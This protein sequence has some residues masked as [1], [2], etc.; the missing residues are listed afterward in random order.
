MNNNGTLISLNSISKYYN[1]GKVKVKALENI[2][3]EIKRGE[4]VA[5]IGPSGSGKS[6]LMNIMGCLDQPTSGSYRLDGQSVAEFSVHQ[7]AHIRNRKIG[8]IFQNFNLLPYATAFEN[9]E[10]PLIFAG[11]SAVIRKEKVM[12]NLSLVGL[13]ERADHKPTELSGGEMQR[14]AI[15]R[16]LANEPDIV[17]ADEPTGNLDSKSG[18]EIIKLFESLNE[19]GTSVVTITHDMNIARRW[20][21]IVKIKDGLI[22]G[23]VRVGV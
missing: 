3:L 8:F 20:N 1:T 16:A 2:N 15:A 9:V 22:E 5:I 6:T 4:L 12:E 7:L 10:L 13:A 21:R 14:V 17:L 19:R 11:K 18:G 23:D